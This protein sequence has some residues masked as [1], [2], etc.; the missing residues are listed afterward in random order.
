MLRPPYQ[1]SVEPHVVE[2]QLPIPPNVDRFRRLDDDSFDVA[3]LAPAV[4][5]VRQVDAELHAGNYKTS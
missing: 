1:L 3:I 4:E 5:Q 2:R